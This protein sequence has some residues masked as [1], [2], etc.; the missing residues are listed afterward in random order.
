MTAIKT[1]LVDDEPRGLSSLQKLLQINCPEVQVMACC[2]SAED[3]KEKIDRLQPQL[4]FLDIAMPGQNGFDLLKS[5]SKISFEVI[6]VT[7]HNS[8]M[9]QAF[10]F[11]AVD[12]LLKP[13][14]DELLKDAVRRAYKRIEQSIHNFPMEA[15]LHNMQHTDRS[16][17]MKLC[18]SSFKGFQ[19]VQLKE[20]LYCEASGSY[21]NFHFIDGHRMV[22][23]KPIY[24]YEELLSNAGFVRIHKSYLVNLEHIKEY[25]RGEGGT[26]LLCTGKQLDVSRRKKERLLARMKEYFRF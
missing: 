1:I 24:E 4:I 7:A 12:Y 21:T 19:V 22:S 6:F 15:L 10:Q 13:V 2:Q 9:L 23:A 8:Y 11:S 18:I 25:F 14:E 16:Q 26:I 17:Q 20:I 3:A 5:L